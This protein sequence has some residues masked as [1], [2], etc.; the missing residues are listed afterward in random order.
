MGRRNRAPKQ[1]RPE[2]IPNPSLAAL[3][4]HACW[5]IPFFLFLVL[6]LFSGDPYYLLG[7]DQCMF[8][9][10][11][12]TFPRHQLFNHEL[13]LIHPPLFGYAI[14]LFYL[15][16]PLLTAGLV[17]TLFFACLAFFAVREL[18]RFEGLPRTAIFAGL[19]YLALSRPAVAFDYHVARVSPLVCAT[20]FA[21]LAFLHLLRE[22]GRKALLVAIA[23]NALALF[24]S[25]Q[26]LLLLP[27]QAIF[28][29]ARGS[30]RA[31]KSAAL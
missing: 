26:A 4:R 8:L 5:L 2:E 13:F 9:E 18:G 20:A 27:C 11:G 30:R 15:F 12:R 29:W 31:W 22:P 19:T 21:I 7:G 28:L 3:A 25:D 17:A 14:G 6:R 23:A 16:L 24:V 10:T 1:S